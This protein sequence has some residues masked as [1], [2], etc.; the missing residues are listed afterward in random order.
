MQHLWDIYGKMEFNNVI[1]WLVSPHYM[2]DWIMATNGVYIHIYIYTP[3]VG[4]YDW[5]QFPTKSG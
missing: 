4:I 1:C 3:I 2:I 5:L